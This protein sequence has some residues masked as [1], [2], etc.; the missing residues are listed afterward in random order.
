LRGEY[1][2]F[3]LTGRMVDRS[4]VWNE[5]AVIGVGHLSPGVYML[6]GDSGSIRFVK[7]W[8]RQY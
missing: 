2:I 7:R 6:N 5:P 1:I 3:D 4:S 8:A